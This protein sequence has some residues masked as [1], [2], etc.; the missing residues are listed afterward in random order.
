MFNW[1]NLFSAQPQPEKITGLSPEWQ[2]AADN[3]TKFTPDIS[4]LTEKTKHLLF[5]YD[6]MKVNFP[7]YSLIQGAEF[8]CPVTTREDRFLL[9]R[10]EHQDCVTAM[11]VRTDKKPD[12]KCKRYDIMKPDPARVRG[13]LHL[14]DTPTYFELDKVLSNGVY[15][16]RERIAVDLPHNKNRWEKHRGSW[17]PYEG[18]SY[19]WAYTYLTTQEQVDELPY[20]SVRGLNLFKPANR[21]NNLKLISDK[22]YYEFTRLELNGKQTC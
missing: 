5:V 3:R 2:E 19:V 17:Q 10:T 22:P 11:A 18:P 21:N 9:W 14:V 6:S 7:R 13:Q 4:V 12:P 8:L 20:R 16:K 1:R 15:Y